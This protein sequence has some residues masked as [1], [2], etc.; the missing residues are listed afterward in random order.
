[1]NEREIKRLIRLVEQSEIHELEITQGDQHI[2][3]A[4]SATAA[5]VP[6]PPAPLPP[7]AEA[8]SPPEPEP[9]GEQPAEDEGLRPIVAPIVGTFYSSPAPDADPFVSVGSTVEVGQ[10]VC[11]IEAMKVMN[12]IGAEIAGVVR[13]IL[14]ENAQP[15]E[16]G[17]PL[18]LVET[19][20]S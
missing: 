18:F 6:Q 4:K 14:V 3:I 2:R 7:R 12:P 5:P 11:I 1:M 9:T 17:E 10:T 20:T 8:A 13:K 19:A 16:Y 15:V